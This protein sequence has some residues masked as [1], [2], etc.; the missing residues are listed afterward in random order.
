[1]ALSP[2]FKPEGS[3]IAGLAVVGLVIA[4]YN[5]HSGSASM[6]AATDPWDPSLKASNAKAGWSS[7]ALVAGVALLA[8]D[9]NIVILGG[10]AII[11][12]HSSYIHAIAVHPQTGAIIAPSPTAASY[13]PA[14]DT[15]AAS[16]SVYAVA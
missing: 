1:M 3:I 5:L 8:R 2:V 9:P 6:A 4:N 15:T 7:L 12:M 10:A 14:S 16:A 13:A 11:A